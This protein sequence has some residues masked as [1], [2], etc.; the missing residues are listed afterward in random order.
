MSDMG[1]ILRLAFRNLFRNLRR[2]VITSGAIVA[3]VAVLIG[4]MGLVD[5]LD[6]NVLRANEQAMTGHVLLRPDGYPTDGRSL[7]LEQAVP[8]PAELV[9]RLDSDPRI[10]SWTP[11]TWF[12]GRAVSGVD[13]MTVRAFTYDDAREA[14][15][16][17]RER[18][19][20]KGAWP[21]G[22]GQVVVGQW[23]A[24]L[25]ELEPGADLVLEARTRA[26]AINALGLRVTGI[27]HTGTPAADRVIWVPQQTGELLIVPE[28]AVSHVALRLDRRAQ[29][30]AVVAALAGT[31]WTA[32]T[33]SWEARDLLALNAFRRK[34]ISLVVLVLLLIAGTGIAN[35]VIMAAYERIREVGTLRAM[36]MTTGGIRALF[37]VEGAVLGMSAGLVGALLGGTL[38]AWFSAHGIDLSGAADQVGDLAMSSTLYMRFSWGPILAALAFGVVVSVLASIYPANHAARLNPADAVRAD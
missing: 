25:L 10:Q 12:Q 19:V 11:R 33:A 8:L 29:A 18:W 37:L 28:G 14:A 31:G 30:D 7:P 34:A 27:V 20:L 24:G 23:L 6:E 9:S 1:L 5:G 21:D 13:G 32:T 36:G 16:F 3:G 38:V 15:T 17:A 2:T 35:T 26:G 4:G 22:P